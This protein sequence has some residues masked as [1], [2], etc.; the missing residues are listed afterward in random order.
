LYLIQHEGMTV[1]DVG[2]LLTNRSGLLGV[3]GLS[4]DIRE[5]VASGEPAAAEAL[6]LFVY[7]AAWELGALIASIGGLDALVFTAGIGEH[8]PVIRQQ[9]AERFK[10]LGVD[11]DERANEMGATRISS[12]K[13]AID[14]LMIPTNEELVIARAA[15]AFI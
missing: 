12:S 9:I 1:N 7:R 6:E 11:I 8:S 13:S 15:A 4:D 3:S 14:V 5:L 2:D 10:W